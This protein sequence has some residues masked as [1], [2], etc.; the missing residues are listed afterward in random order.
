MLWFVHSPGEMSEG[1]IEMQHAALEKADIHTSGV[2]KP[3]MN[4]FLLICAPTIFLCSSIV[5]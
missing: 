2:I 3:L 1:W 4:R 5:F